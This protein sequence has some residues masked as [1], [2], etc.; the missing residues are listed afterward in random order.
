[1]HCHSDIN[2]PVVLV[3]QG[4]DDINVPRVMGEYLAAHLAG[5]KAVVLPG[6]G[7]LTTLTKHAADI[8]LQLDAALRVG[9]TLER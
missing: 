1:L 6:E 4:E 7:H 3:F 5:A 2:A 9:C 8:L